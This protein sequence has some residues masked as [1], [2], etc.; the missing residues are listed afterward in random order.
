MAYLRDQFNIFEWLALGIKHFI[1]NLMFCDHP[2]C[3]SLYK[4]YNR[5]YNQNK[6]EL[7]L[8]IRPGKIEAINVL[9]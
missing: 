9:L 7:Y 8:D 2:E 4:L 1:T 6:M 5:F 3:T